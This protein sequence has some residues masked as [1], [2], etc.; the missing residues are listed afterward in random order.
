M[1]GLGTMTVLTIL[2]LLLQGDGFLWSLRVT[3]GE[4]TSETSN[5]M[6]AQTAISYAGLAD[7]ISRLT[8]SGPVLF[9]VAQILATISF[10]LA[11]ALS[12]FFWKR[13][14]RWEGWLALTLIPMVVLPSSQVYNL[15]I[16]VPLVLFG[17]IS[18]DERDRLRIHLRQLVAFLLLPHGASLADLGISQA[19]PTRI[20]T[21]L[22][23]TV[24]FV[25]FVVLSTLAVNVIKQTRTESRPGSVR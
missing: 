20:Q 9:R 22:V 5:E 1:L 16:L 10:T 3:L 23:P 12:A 2:S 14:L 19:G 11:L 18:I 7:L 15:A 17:S 4:V 24:G 25:L 13:G 6:W 8:A 21:V